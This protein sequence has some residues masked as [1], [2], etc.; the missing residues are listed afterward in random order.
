MRFELSH[1]GRLG[2]PNDGQSRSLGCGRRF[3]NHYNSDALS[4]VVCSLA[5]Q[6][7][8]Y[9]EEMNKVKR[10]HERTVEVN[11]ID[12]LVRDSSIVLQQQFQV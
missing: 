9:D 12:H 5:P 4:S 11:M 7:D 8:A 2:G 3:R 10:M 1:V 6:P